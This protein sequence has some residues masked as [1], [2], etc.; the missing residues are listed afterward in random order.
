M[1]SF[2]S[3]PEMIFCPMWIGI[4][5]WRLSRLNHLLVAENRRIV[6]LKVWGS[7]PS[8]CILVLKQQHNKPK[9]FIS[10]WSGSD[11]EPRCWIWYRPLH[12][13]A[14]ELLNLF[15]NFCSWRHFLEG[16]FIAE[17]LKHKRRMLLWPVY[18]YLLVKKIYSDKTDLCNFNCAL[19]C[20]LSSV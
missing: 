5:P 14:Q 13:A 17:R 3:V 8:L 11:A 20:D 16:V 12:Q 1:S 18:F 15:Q 9:S 2:S 6:S 4:G 19:W 7:R 10:I